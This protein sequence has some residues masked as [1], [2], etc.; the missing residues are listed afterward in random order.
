MLHSLVG[1]QVEDDDQQ[2][3]DGRDVPMVEADVGPV[4]SDGYEDV[5]N[6]HQGYTAEDHLHLL[7]TLFVGKDGCTIEQ[8]SCQHGD[9]QAD[10]AT[11]GASHGTEI[12]EQVLLSN[13][14]FNTQDGEEEAQG[15]D[16]HG[17]QEEDGL[18]T[19]YH[20]SSS[21]PNSSSFLEGSR[22]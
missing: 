16:Q 12:E 3:K 21:W 2:G 4:D 9:E 8:E 22:Q 6:D 1:H 20:A 11:H 18:L 10:V 14:S 7:V 15:D 13:S 19:L 17:E 5:P